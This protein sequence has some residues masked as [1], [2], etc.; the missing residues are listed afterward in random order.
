MT[1]TV[2]AA[3]VTALAQKEVK[4]FYAVELE[5]DTAAVRFWTGF[6]SKTVNGDAYTGAG[7]LLSISG[8]EE[9]ADLSAR[10]VTLTLD[11][12]PAEL[13]ALALGE[14]Y[15]RRPCNIYFGVDGV[16]D[17]VNVFTGNMNMMTIQDSGETGS[18]TLLV[19]SKLVELERSTNR[20]YTNE[21]IRDFYSS[22]TFFS[23]VDKLQDKKL[24]WGRK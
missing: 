21:A 7:Y 14:N 13:I 18:I 10:S 9:V 5:F 23:Y 8:L 22:D 4:P 1:R 16:S 20:R 15:Q 6:G 17:V 24:S 2:P 3:I 12:I 11:G 19:D